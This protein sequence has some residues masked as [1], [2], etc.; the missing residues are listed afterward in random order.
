[1][2]NFSAF[3][4]KNKK[5]RENSFYAA[6]KSLCD[7]KGEPLLWEIRP[8][9]TKEIEKIRDANMKE[10]PVNGKRGQYR[11]KMDTTGFTDDLMVAAIVSP[12]L[13][14]QELQDSY[15][16]M[17]PKDLLKAMVDNPSEYSDLSAHIQMVS[18][19][20]VDMSEEVEEAKN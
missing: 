5:V 17:T 3:M 1:M 13:Y 7:E 18:G 8:L 19:Y 11:T 9:N 10:I 12:D 2:S 15:G 20:D 16:V 6:T 14:N 4:K